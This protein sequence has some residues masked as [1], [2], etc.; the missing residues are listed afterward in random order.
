MQDDIMERIIKA[1]NGDDSFLLKEL[2]ALDRSGRGLVDIANFV[3]FFLRNAPQHIQFLR[4]DLM[5]LGQKYAKP[6]NN[7][8]VDINEFL[9]EFARIR[10][11]NGF[12]AGYY[13]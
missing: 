12:N 10:K 11:A 7:N 9:N 1:F 3:D 5:F 4:N 8:L 13:H 6:M 2:M